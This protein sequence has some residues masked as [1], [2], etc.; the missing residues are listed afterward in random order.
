MM[1]DRNKISEGDAPRETGHG[2]IGREREG[3]RD[4]EREMERG[5]EERAEPPIPRGRKLIN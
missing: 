3:A 5:R 2:G 1:E 4:G